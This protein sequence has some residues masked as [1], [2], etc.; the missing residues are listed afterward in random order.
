[1]FKIFK[2][3]YVLCVYSNIIIIL[4]LLI[5]CLFCLSIHVS[6]FLKTILKKIRLA[7]KKDN[8]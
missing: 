4:F 6:M 8:S 3:E 5:S 1:M 2:H 7:V